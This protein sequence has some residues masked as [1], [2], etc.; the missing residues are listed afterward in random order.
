MD[1]LRNRI[2]GDDHIRIQAVI[3]RATVSAIKSFGHSYAAGYWATSL[4]GYAQQLAADLNV[5]LSDYAVGG[6]RLYH[7]ITAAFEHPAIAGD[8]ILFNSGLNDLRLAS[9]TLTSAKAKNA[10]RS[11]LASTFA[12]TA[13]GAQALTVKWP[14][15]WSDLHSKSCWLNSGA[16]QSTAAG[17]V[18]EHVFDGDNFVVGF[19]GCNGTTSGTLGCTE[20]YVD[21]ILIGTF[22]PNGQTDGIMTEEM[23]MPVTWRG[24]GAA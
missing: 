18:A 4:N 7:A 22:N 3:N 20:I 24:Y 21:N 5:P 17:Q 13:V 1:K 9:G 2:G 6:S 12:K 8:L 15:T 23:F 16:I 14:G 19:M 10:I 11:L